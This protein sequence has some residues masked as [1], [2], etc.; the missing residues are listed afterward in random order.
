[1]YVKIKP[2]RKTDKGGYLMMPMKKNV[3]NPQNETW[4]ET[5]CP[6][7]GCECWNRPLPEG[8][9]EEMFSGKLCT[10]CAINLSVQY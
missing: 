3:P 8:Y 9:E 2:R 6:K 5:V 10:A 4:T 1:M 7:C